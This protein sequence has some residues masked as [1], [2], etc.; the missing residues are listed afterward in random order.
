MLSFISVARLQHLMGETLLLVCNVLLL[1]DSLFVILCLCFRPLSR[2]VLCF[3]ACFCSCCVYILSLPPCREPTGDT[4]KHTAY[5][6]SHS[7][8]QTNFRA[9]IG[10]EYETRCGC[11]IVGPVVGLSTRSQLRARNTFPVP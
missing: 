3:I 11:H 2:H 5:R 6:C 8:P 10:R 1:F 7:A 9:L 4:C